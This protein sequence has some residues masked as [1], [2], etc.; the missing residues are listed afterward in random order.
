MQLKTH[1]G[2]ALFNAIDLDMSK[3]YLH[4]SL[5][6]VVADELKLAAKDS[7]VTLDQWVIFPDALHALIFL[8]EHGRDR[9]VCSINNR[10][11]LK[12]KPR[13]LTSF[14]AGLKTVTAKRI[15]LLRNQPGS[16]VWQRSY[17]EQLIKDDVILSRLKKNIGEADSIVMCG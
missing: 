16:P 10:S 1:N 12:G 5:T 3:D 9:S 15:N 17:K 14:I 7:R 13:C 8:H 11:S 4:T 6:Q 2:H